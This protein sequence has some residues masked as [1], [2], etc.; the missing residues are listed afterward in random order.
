MLYDR[1]VATFT[2]Q[3]FYDKNSRQTLPNHV[4]LQKHSAIAK[5]KVIKGLKG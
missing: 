3:L 4:T 1:N 5:F 2:L